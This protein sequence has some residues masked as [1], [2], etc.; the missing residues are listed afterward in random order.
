MPLGLTGG[1]LLRST[2]RPIIS[3]HGMDRV[4]IITRLARSVVRL[5]A[6]R[7]KPERHGREE[8]AGG[9]EQVAK[10]P[11]A[12]PPS[13]TRRH[14][15]PYTARH[16]ALKVKR[17][18]T[19]SMESVTVTVTGLHSSTTFSEESCSVDLSEKKGF[20]L[21]SELFATVVR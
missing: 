4:L 21:R 8:N 6:G 13:M 20:Q 2:A 16:V 1:R 7:E 19:S 14:C 12:D 10:P 5:D 9:H 15:R 18:I 3:R 11:A 17:G